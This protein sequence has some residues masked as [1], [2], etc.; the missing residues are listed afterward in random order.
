MVNDAQLMQL[1]CLPEEPT[2]HGHAE[3]GRVPFV[4]TGPQ[5]L[6]NAA[7]RRGLA[8]SVAKKAAPQVV[9]AGPLIVAVE[10]ELKPVLQLALMVLI[11]EDIA[12]ARDGQLGVARFMQTAK[13]TAFAVEWLRVL[14][15]GS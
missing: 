10:L 12:I 11:Q 1:H 5:C 13:G 14:G 2:C 6:E 7:D 4:L 9:L 3:I 15:E 8:A